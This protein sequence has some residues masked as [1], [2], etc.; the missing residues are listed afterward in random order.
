MPKEKKMR[1]CGKCAKAKHHGS[2]SGTSIYRKM[3]QDCG[4]GVPN[5]AMPG[6][7]ALWCKLCADKSHPE[8]HD[9]RRLAT[10]SGGTKCESCD[11][12]AYYCKP[13]DEK[14]RW[15]GTCS[16]HHPGA[17]RPRSKMCEDCS[18]KMPKWGLVDGKRRWC[19]GCAKGH[20]GSKPLN[21]RYCEDCVTKYAGFSMPKDKKPRWCASCAVKHIGSL[22]RHNGK[23]ASGKIAVASK[24]W[25]D[26]FAELETYKKKTG[27]CDVKTTASKLGR[28]VAA[29]RL[30][31]KELAAGEASQLTEE[32]FNKLQGLDF[33]WS[34]NKTKPKD[35]SNKKGGAKKK[36]TTLPHAAAAKAAIELAMAKKPVRCNVPKPL[37]ITEPL[38]PITGLLPSQDCRQCRNP[39]NR[40]AH[41]CGKSPEELAA[42]N[43][44]E[45]CDVECR[46]GASSL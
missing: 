36:S 44:F 38:L 28:W 10:W 8:A 14:P 46:N 23:K 25:D 18:Q 22:S 3:C 37:G 32:R 17:V 15:C 40:R 39:N 35:K 20:D 21:Q 26:R 41:T 5:F 9:K 43:N 42:A 31:G 1:W 2:D 30:Q 16:K 19:S 45:I 27:D 34:K 33:I 6:G 7:K 13:I 11:K 29:Q 24:N 12:R 4:T